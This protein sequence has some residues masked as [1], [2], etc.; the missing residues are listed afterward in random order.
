MNLRGT[1]ELFFTYIKSIISLSCCEIVSSASDASADANVLFKMMLRNISFLVITWIKLLIAQ[2]EPKFSI[3]CIYIHSL[4]N[5][6]L[7][8]FII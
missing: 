8:Q 7:Y 6:T 5:Y 2:V 4:H 1:M 3:P